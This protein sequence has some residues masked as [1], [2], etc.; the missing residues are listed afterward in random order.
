MEAG[1]VRSPSLRIWDSPRHVHQACLLA[2]DTQCARRPAEGK[3]SPLCGTR[4]DA[5]SL[6]HGTRS[7]FSRKHTDEY[8]SFPFRSG[9]FQTATRAC[10]LGGVRVVPRAGSR[11]RVGA[12]DLRGL[13]C[14]GAMDRELG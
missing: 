8:Q 11:H 7:R 6:E 1:A 5:G 3:P 9:T 10:L 13:M 2:V 12:G 14:T 4:E